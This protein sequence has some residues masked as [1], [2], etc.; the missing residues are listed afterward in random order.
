MGTMVPCSLPS[1]GWSSRAS[2]WNQSAISLPKCFCF[3]FCLQSS[4]CWVM[5]LSFVFIFLECCSSLWRMTRML[6]GLSPPQSKLGCKHSRNVMPPADALSLLP[7]TQLCVCLVQAINV[8]LFDLCLYQSPLLCEAQSC[9]QSTLSLSGQEKGEDADKGNSREET[10][11]SHGWRCTVLPRAKSTVLGEVG[12][13]HRGSGFL[14]AYKT[15]MV[16]TVAGCRWMQGNHPIVW[17]RRGMV[18][19]QCW[20]WEGEMK[21]EGERVRLESG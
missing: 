1:A 2:C 16:G 18:E 12:R 7:N 11:F 10:C 4:K 8:W 14:L 15:Q 9:A 3:A 5:L 6:F 21:E 19:Y 20:C 13:P 17:Q